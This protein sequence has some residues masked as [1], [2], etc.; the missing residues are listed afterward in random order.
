MNKQN[1]CVEFSFT[2]LYKISFTESETLVIDD[3]LYNQIYYIK[4]YRKSSVFNG[5]CYY[6]VLFRDLPNKIKILA[7]RLNA[8]SKCEPA[9]P[10]KCYLSRLIY[11]LY[12]NKPIPQGHEIHHVNNNSLDN[13]PSNLECL[14]RA[15]HM[16]RHDYKNPFKD[17]YFTIED[18]KP[19]KRQKPHY[20]AK[21]NKIIELIKQGK[22]NRHIIKTL[23]C[24]NS[25]IQKIKASLEKSGFNFIFLLFKKLSK[26][27]LVLEGFFCV[28]SLYFLSSSNVYS[29][30]VSIYSGL[31]Q[32]TS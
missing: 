32:N 6:Y 2:T 25:T 8:V 31:A 9:E 29:F 13:T 21:E 28:I 26:N 24:H 1:Y 10:N 30:V 23:K 5:K 19:A 15:D 4:V 11:V 18:L 20:K 14:S 27:A 12:T 3:F 16:A 22:S 7:Y 17:Q